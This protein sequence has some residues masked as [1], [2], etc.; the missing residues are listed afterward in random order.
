MLIEV[1]P[2][3]SRRSFRIICIRLYS[4]TRTP[5]GHLGKFRRSDVRYNLKR[6]SLVTKRLC[7]ILAAAFAHWGAAMALTIN[8]SKAVKHLK[9]NLQLI[10]CAGSGKTEVVANHITNLMASS[11]NGG[12]GLSPANIIAFTFTEKAAAELKQRVLDRCRE[13]H[14]GIAGLAEM[15][16]GTIHGYCLNLLRSEVPNFLKYD[17]LNEVQQILLVNR[18]SAKSGLTTT[19]TL[20]GQ[21][22]RR[23]SDT[24]LYIQAM[25][26]LRETDI[27]KSILKNLS[28]WNGLE[29]YEALLHEKSFFDYSAIISEATRCLE[30][31]KSLKLKLSS[32]IKVVIVD[33]YQDVNPIQERLVNALHTLGAAIRVVGDDDQTIY[34]WRGSDVQNILQFTNRYSNVKTIKREENF[35]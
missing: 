10:A 7:D 16:I 19:S 6:L 18:N 5:F 15:Y 13:Q 11:Q 21:K 34:Q 3:G 8:Q 32:R 9:G 31:D 22:L 30:K 1:F 17:V 35:R 14:P 26:V 33:E 24:P 28:I 20:N 4:L 12:A 23:Y 25:S 29:Q 2:L 27:N